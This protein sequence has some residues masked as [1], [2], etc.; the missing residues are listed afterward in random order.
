MSTLSDDQIKYARYK[1]EFL[2]RNPEYIKDWENLEDVLYE[3]YGDYSPPS[4]E[5]S[6]EEIDFCKKWGIYGQM[7]PHNSYDDYTTHIID[8]HPYPKEEKDEKSIDFDYMGSAVNESSLTRFG[9]DLHRTMFDR[10][11][12][13]FIQL[14]PFTVMDGWEYEYV[15]DL[16]VMRSFSDK[17]AKSGIL[18]IKIDLNHSKN[19]L[20]NEFKLFIDEWKKMYEAAFI[21]FRYEKFCEERN[22]RHHPIEDEGLQKE[23]EGIYVDRLKERKE[24]YEKKYHFDN[25]DLYL[26]VYDLRQEG[27]SWSKITSD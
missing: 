8:R 21:N 25:F 7:P 11:F 26:Q 24:K 2:R 23:F 19:R 20:I 18:T 27:K 4:G 15:E 22:I 5:M 10:M 13:E 9:V 1:W 17:V 3:K 16:G 6:K 14:R 12:P